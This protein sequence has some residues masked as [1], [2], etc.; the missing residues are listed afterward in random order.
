MHVASADPTF[1][2]SITTM[3]TE[4]A[5]EKE[6]EDKE[7]Q[8]LGDAEKK[9]QAL[10]QNRC[11]AAWEANTL[12]LCRDASM[13]ARVL[14]AAVSNEKTRRLM[15]V[16]HLREQNSIGAQLVT[17]FAEK[18]CFHVPLVCPEADSHLAKAWLFPI[19]LLVP[20]STCNFL[21]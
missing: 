17:K 10:D 9:I 12:K 5:P 8:A 16:T 11:N 4:N 2:A 21:P 18:Q 14:Q 1:H 20:S 7:N 15:K 6:A 3:W 19:K 13:C